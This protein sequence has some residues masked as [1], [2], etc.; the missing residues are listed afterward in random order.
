MCIF[1]L[2]VIFFTHKQTSPLPVKGCKYWPLLDTHGLWEVRL[3][4]RVTPTVTR[5]TLGNFRGPLTF[6]SVVDNLTGELTQPGLTCFHDLGL[7]RLGSVALGFEHWTF[8]LQEK[9]FNLL[10]P[11]QLLPE[12]LVDW[13]ELYAVSAIFQ[14]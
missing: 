13:I 5:G 8:C 12:L 1:H 6:T 9:R 7:S 11:T 2:Y 14:T 3:L 10:Y 4:Q